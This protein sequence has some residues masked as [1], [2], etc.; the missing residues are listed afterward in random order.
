MPYA[1]AVAI[2]MASWRSLRPLLDPSPRLRTHCGLRKM[3]IEASKRPGRAGRA[4]AELADGR[5][6]SRTRRQAGLR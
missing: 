1:A 5:E 6:G 4:L 2:L 3:W